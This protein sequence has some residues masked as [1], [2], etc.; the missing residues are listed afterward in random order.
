MA[1]QCRGAEAAVGNRSQALNSVQ[2]SE[3]LSLREACKLRAAIAL[4]RASDT[5][6]AQ[7]IA[8]DLDK[9]FPLDTLVQNY[10]LPVVR[11]AISLNSH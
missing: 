3:A 6:H 8:D 7:E 10:Y 4:A 2:E 5:A 9:E 1:G 11:A